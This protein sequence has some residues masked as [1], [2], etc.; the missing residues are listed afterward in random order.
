MASQILVICFE[1]TWERRVNLAR[2][3]RKSLRG[4][5]QLSFCPSFGQLVTKRERVEVVVRK[6][7]MKSSTTIFY[8]MVKAIFKKYFL[9]HM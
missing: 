4:R 5:R 7:V 3:L 9:Q 2:N 1:V 6:S 8:I